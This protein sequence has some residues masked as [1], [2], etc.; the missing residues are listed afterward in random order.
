[1][2]LLATLT[3]YLVARFAHSGRP[4]WLYAAGAAMGLTF[5][6]KETSLILIGAVY[7]FLALS[8]EIRLTVRDAVRSLAL[9]AA[10]AALYPL[11]LLLA[12]ET[13][14][15]GN[16]LLWQVFRRPNHDWHFYAESVGPALG[17]I[18]LAAA[19]A[20]LWFLRRDRSWRERLLVS[21]IAVVIVFF[22][23]WPVKGFPYL[24]P[25]APALAVLA[26]RAL[27]AWPRRAGQPRARAG[28]VV[29]VALLA[30][31]LAV[32]TWARI[33]PSVSPTFLAGSGGV[34]GGREAGQWVAEHVP[35]GAQIMTIGPSMANILQFY[36]QRKTW[37]LSVSTNPLHR[38]PVYE[39][40]PNP[41]RVIKSAELQYIVWD[42]FSAA[43]SPHFAGKIRR[44]VDRYGGRLVYADTTPV[45]TGGDAVA[46][47]PLIA[48]YEVRP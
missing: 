14:T 15:G 45:K 9:L 46:A 36:G 42:T 4:E 13:G 23:L 31:S 8:P 27:A 32:P 38:N 3:L 19:L 7:A 41:D 11:C 20:G 44:F 24:L 30:L 18:T 34:P 26:G 12:G 2:V 35:R 48:I 10:V 47:A 29:V 28:P 5:L 17:W 21:W 37:A 25:M 43:R 22:Q 39:P 16:F 33:Q 1:M 6:V 40:L